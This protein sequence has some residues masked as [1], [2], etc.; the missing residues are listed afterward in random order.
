MGP[1]LTLVSA[2]TTCFLLMMVAGGLGPYHCLWP[3][4]APSKRFFITPTFGG[5]IGAVRFVVPTA[6]PYLLPYYLQTM[7]VKDFFV[8]GSTHG[9]P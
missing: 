2:L 7:R 4:D 3:N 1:I 6:K 9:L 8:S 5:I